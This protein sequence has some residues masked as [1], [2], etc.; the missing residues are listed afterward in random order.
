MTGGFLTAMIWTRHTQVP[1]THFSLGTTM[2]VSV[3]GLNVGVYGVFTMADLLVIEREDGTLL[4]AKAIPNGMLGY[5]LGKVVNISGQIAF[6][7]A[8]TLLTG[9]FLFTGLTTSSAGRWLTLAWVLVLG[10]L[11][12][13]PLGAVLGSLFPSQRSAGGRWCCC[14]PDLARSPASST[15]SR[16]CRC[17]CNGPGR[18]SRCTGWGW[19]CVPRCCR[20]R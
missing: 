6:A 20:T 19:G 9:A 16:T 18:C 13:L 7:V 12:T 3:L 1:G 15:R 5:L 10:L 14:W 4:R 17:S 8:A 2:L 11:A